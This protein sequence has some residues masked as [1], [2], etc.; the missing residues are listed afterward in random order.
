M[1]VYGPDNSTTKLH[2]SV[3][4]CGRCTHYEFGFGSTVRNAKDI[5][6]TILSDRI[7][8]KMGLRLAVHSMQ[9]LLLTL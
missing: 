4:I 2:H 3:G 7:I 1:S 6:Y 9:T 5:G 8:E